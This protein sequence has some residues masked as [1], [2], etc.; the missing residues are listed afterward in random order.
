[1]ILVANRENGTWYASLT[2]FS[3]GHADTG[4]AFPGSL[5]IADKLVTIT[6]PLTSLRMPTQLRLG[7]VSQRAD[8]AHGAV[9]AEDEAPKGASTDKPGETWL[10]LK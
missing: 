10:T 5:F 4:D 6:V 1:M 9:L 8:H 2:D 3:S 7:V